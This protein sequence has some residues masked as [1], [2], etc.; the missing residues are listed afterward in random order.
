[1][2]SSSHLIFVPGGGGLRLM[3]T[4][5]GGVLGTAGA[6]KAEAKGSSE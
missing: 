1:M 4:W 2:A 5:E 6:T 3:I